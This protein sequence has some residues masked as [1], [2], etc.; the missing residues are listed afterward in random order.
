MNGYY[1]FPTIRGDQVV[2]AAD[3]DLWSV[4]STGGVARRL[5]AGV[6]QASHPKLSPDGRWLAFTGRDD[7]PAEIYVMNASGGEARRLT[8]QGAYALA[9]GWTPDGAQVV[10]AS[11]AAQPSSRIT[12]LWTVPVDGGVPQRLPWGYAASN[13]WGP[14]GM[15]A[16]GRF[17]ADPARWKRYRGGTA[18][19]IWVDRQGDGAFEPLP[20][21][22]GNY[23]AP[24]WIGDRLYF[25]GDPDGYGNL[26]SCRPDGSDWTR[27][28]GH[29]RFYARGASTDGTHIIYHCGGDL[30]LFDPA[31]GSDRAL[32]VTLDSAR[33]QLRPRWID[34]AGSLQG[35]SLAPKGDGVAVNA[36]GRCFAMGPWHGPAR[37][38]GS[39]PGVR[40]RM[41]EWLHDGQRVAVVSDATGEERLEVRIP[42]DPDPVCTFGDLDVGRVT[43]IAPSPVADLIAL[44]N[45]RH[46]LLLID[47]ES[48]SMEQ[49]AS[50]EYG[51]IGRPAWSSDGQWLSFNVPVSESGSAIRLFHLADRSTT[52]V[53]SGEFMDINPDWD[54]D[55][56]YLYFVSYRDFTP[57]WD[58]LLFDLGFTFGGRPYL[59]TLQKGLSNPFLPIDDP[60]GDE[61]KPKDTPAE[62]TEG[63][64]E[65]PAPHTGGTEGAGDSDSAK[66]ADDAPK[67][68][69][70]DLDGLAERVCVFP[71]PEQRY[72]FAGGVHG[73]VVLGWF[74]VKGPEPGEHDGGMEL[75]AWDLHERK[76]DHLMGG[77]RGV[78]FSA[79]H[80]WI[81]LNLEPNRLRLLK[82]G[83]KPDAHAPATAGRK[84]GWI[85]LNRVRI[86]VLPVPEWR[87]MVREAWRLQRDHFWTEDMSGVDW[88][89]VLERYLPL[90]DRLG[91]RSELS[92]LI[93]EMQG[94][95]GTSHCYEYGGDYRPSPWAGVGMLGA[96]VCWDSETAS[97]RIT[98][99]I[100]GDSWLV[101]AD[102]ALREPGVGLVE[103]DRILAVNGTP[104]DADTPPERLMENQ[105]GQL[106][107][108]R[109]QRQG[110][111]APESVVIR[112]LGSE[113]SARY[114]DWVN[115]NRAVVHQRFNGRVGYLHV[116]D[117]MDRGFSE[118][119]RGYLTEMGREGLIVD[120]RFNGGGCVSGLLL[121]KLAR[122]IIGYDVPRRGK[123][124]SYPI[125]TYPGPIVAITNEDA[126]SDGDIF[127]HG[128]KLM[129]LGTLVGKRTWGGVI[130]ISPDMPLMDGAITTQPEYSF[131]FNDVG[132]AV[133][134]YGTDPDIEVEIRPQDYRDGRDPQLD[135][136][137]RVMEEQLAGRPASPPDFG[138]RPSNR[139][140]RLD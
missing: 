17:T 16:L 8:W 22:A 79:D 33:P 45:H 124:M 12:N 24:M 64:P 127:S 11:S 119:H 118:F 25:I 37:A 91:S 107:E 117:M 106:I 42:G 81:L 108:L 21:P 19:R 85:D 65:E 97:W 67:P 98:R 139:P 88:R 137:M 68:V 18:G 63:A 7:G 15:V 71:V 62:S 43:A 66:P 30:R 1:R 32:T 109:V 2:F 60:G 26:Y 49:I 83:D 76:L 122:K 74:P 99:V 103:G 28:T 138:P 31:D 102:S 52:D 123:P 120:V 34:T 86:Q 9:V 51:R 105:A 94:E 47:L 70:I 111:E 87:Q 40:H 135:T 84:S 46:E 58:S 53:T 89:E 128:F 126:G 131:W 90:V 13:A 23:A 134:N 14:N 55:G 110:D 44:T 133:E 59:V 101:D 57:V 4:P 125:Q 104:L 121:E 3:D 114:R 48:G 82:A 77:V 61:E 56:K 27:H 41:P 116:P 96:D 38:A 35:F 29:T 80:K 20:M 113:Y 132:W 112:A 129:K 50:S 6:A 130:G 54:P 95:L 69:Q 75:A 73:K 36:R 10:Y 93:W 136:A 5:T 140:P 92:D 115:A 100:H 72:A 78:A 39:E